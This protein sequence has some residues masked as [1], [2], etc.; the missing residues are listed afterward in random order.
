[1]MTEAA[2]LEGGSADG[3]KTAKIAETL[4]T[5]E[6]STVAERRRGDGE[7]YYN[8]GDDRLDRDD[9]GGV[10][11]VSE[12]IKTTEE[13]VEEINTTTADGDSV[14][15]AKLVERVSKTKD[16]GRYFSSSAQQQDGQG[17]EGAV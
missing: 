1:M 17:A 11:L 8:Q 7:G 9:G 2:R 15:S 13:T 3:K 16:L 12:V 5:T 6:M 10:E 14:D 4:E